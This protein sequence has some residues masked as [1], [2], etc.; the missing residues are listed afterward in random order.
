ML[1]LQSQIL[2][3]DEVTCVACALPGAEVMW[4]L[5]CVCDVSPV[6]KASN[7]GSDVREI[8]NSMPA[9]SNDHFSSKQYIH[10]LYSYFPCMFPADSMA[11]YVSLC[12]S[13]P[14]FSDY[15]SE[16]ALPFPQRTYCLFIL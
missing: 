4:L 3:T 8:M 14:V 12:V 11:Y 10:I 2:P 13:V 15:C 7:T 1:V 16:S 9:Y 5:L 6:V